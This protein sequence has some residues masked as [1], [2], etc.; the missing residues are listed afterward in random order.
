MLASFPAIYEN[1]YFGKY[2][3]FRIESLVFTLVQKEREIAFEAMA[4]EKI[5]I[6]FK[7]EALTG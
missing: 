6:L 7:A 3:S 4:P 5:K 2:F 1:V